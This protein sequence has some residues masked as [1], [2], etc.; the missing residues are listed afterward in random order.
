[1]EN[2]EKFLE[3]LKGVLGSYGFSPIIAWT[4][5]FFLRNPYE[6]LVVINREGKI[7]FM[8]RGSEKSFGLPEGGGVGMEIMELVPDSGLPRVLETGIPSIGRLFEVKNIRKIGSSYPLIR[9]GE[10]IGAIGRLIFRSLE[11]VER[12]NTEMNVLKREVKFLR[13]S[14][15]QE[16][17]PHYTFENILGISDAIK[18]AI[19]VAKKIAV[20]ETDVLII[21]ESGT[22]KEL[23][24]QSIHN[25][26]KPGK[27]FFTVNCPAIPFEL[28][29]SELFGYERG[30]FSGASST[31]KPGK[32]ELAH[33]GSIF[34]DEVSSLPLSIQAKLL[35]VFQ[36]REVERLG[37]TSTKK[38]NF[39]LIATTNE[40]LTKLVKKG[41][42][43]EDLYYRIAKTTICIEPLRKRKGDIPIYIDHFLKTINKRF[44]TQF[45]RFSNEALDCL[46][47]YNWPGNVR[48]LINVIEQASLSKWEGE[49][50]P[51]SFLP[52]ELIGSSS[53]PSS[54]PS[55]GI[56][57]EIKEREKALILQALEQ[58]G[59]N[60]RRAVYL[61]GM[62]RSTLY[63]KLKQYNI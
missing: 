18:Q 40:D 35:R 1:M 53:L 47:N 49:E 51:M 29:E 13:E 11:Q 46:M 6:S 4:L 9:N 15:M 54:F 32:F 38:T 30:A 22:G 43:R 48:E 27:P 19:M 56:K 55:V 34:L 24:A 12:I 5:R 3:V 23:F 17:H 60:K 26:Y 8:D 16:H 2:D 57:K 37:S 63:N 61:L 21:G 42:F 36:E 44:N 59:G 39:R 52:P 28:A 62:P 33:N 58:T 45:K 14:Q 50:I 10:V 31:G 41:K 7:G 20:I 25:F